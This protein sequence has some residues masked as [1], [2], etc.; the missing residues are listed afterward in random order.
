MFNFKIEEEFKR[1]MLEKQTE[2]YDKQKDEE[3]KKIKVDSKQKILEDMQNKILTYKTEI[4]KNVSK[5]N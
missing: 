2:R 1:I 5:R 4:F 3:V